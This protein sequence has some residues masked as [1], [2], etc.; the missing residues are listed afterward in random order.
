M[1][2]PFSEGG[3][4]QIEQDVM[5]RWLR[6]FKMKFHQAHASGHC[7]VAD[8]KWLIEKIRPKAVV[9][10]HTEHSEMFKKFVKA[11]IIQPKYGKMMEI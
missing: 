4:D 3:I 10:L 2:E 8:L 6:H 9:P 7:S 11:K 1:S 5:L